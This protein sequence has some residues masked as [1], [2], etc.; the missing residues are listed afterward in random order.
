MKATRTVHGEIVLPEGVPADRRAHITVQVEDV[1]RAD[2]PSEVVGEWRRDVDRLGDLRSVPF[3]V[4]VPADRVDDRRL[5]SVRAHV[6]FQETGEIAKG[7][8]LSMQ[9]YPVLTRGSGDCAR[10]QVRRV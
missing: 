8:L 1:S 5:Y 6:A 2:A 4:I 9:S 3:E 10:V 7:D